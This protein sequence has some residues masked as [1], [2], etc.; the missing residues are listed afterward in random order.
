LFWKILKSLAFSDIRMNKAYLA[1]GLSI[2]FFMAGSILFFERKPAPA[3]EVVTRQEM[4]VVLKNR[5]VMAD[6]PSTDQGTVI[7]KFA[8]QVSD[9][10]IGGLA[11]DRVMLFRSSAIKDLSMAYLYDSKS[12]VAGMPPLKSDAVEL[13]DGKE[14]EIAYT[15]KEGEMQMLFFDGRKLAES[16]YHAHSDNPITGFVTGLKRS[17]RGVFVES[18]TGA[19]VTI[20]DRAMSEEELLNR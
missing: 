2:V 4:V 6:L 7:V 12:L 20:T 16:M 3:P 13:L 14:H 8:A 10:L 1:L 5:G 15:F 11:P 9:V 19:D 18:G 17:E